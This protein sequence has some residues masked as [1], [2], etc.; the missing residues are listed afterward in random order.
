MGRGLISH[1]KRSGTNPISILLDQV[2]EAARITGR[3]DELIA[4]RQHGIRDVAAQT[5]GA[6]GYQPY[7]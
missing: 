2:F 3:C 4:R 5:A 6:A 7:F 1:V